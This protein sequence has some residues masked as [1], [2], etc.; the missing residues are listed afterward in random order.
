GFD[1]CHPVKQYGAGDC[2]EGKSRQARR[3]RTQKNREKNDRK[4]YRRVRK[5]SHSVA[6]TY[7]VLHADVLSTAPVASIQKVLC[8][9]YGRQRDDRAT[10]NSHLARLAFGDN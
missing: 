6:C 10:V 9:S 2:G 3:Q 1:G 4:R 7:D 5:T 8:F